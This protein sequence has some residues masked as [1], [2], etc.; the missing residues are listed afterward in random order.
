MEITFQQV[1]TLVQ[2]SGV[3]Y[4]EAKQALEHTGG[5]L[6]EALLYLEKLGRS[7]TVGQ[8]GFYSTQPKHSAAADAL[9][10]TQ[11]AQKHPGSARRGP[12]RLGELWRAFL[13]LLQRVLTNQFEVWRR[14]RMTTS[15][16]ILV[17]ILL[18]VFFPWITGPVLL[19]G[20]IFGYRYR[21]SGPDLNRE[22]VSRVM[23]QV[24]ETVADVT[25]TVRQEFEKGSKK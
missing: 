18:A 21:F 22:S 7:N 20:L 1:E 23:D 6:L 12:D 11:T 14:D 24:S 9:V 15:M 13:D 10:L 19:V 2:K 25:K 4:T 16:P 17:L 8:G 3:T 5:D